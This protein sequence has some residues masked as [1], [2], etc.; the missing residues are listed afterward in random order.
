MREND[1][2][3]E[4]NNS[5]VVRDE[6]IFE[7]YLKTTQVLKSSKNPSFLKSISW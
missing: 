5:I 2:F 1:F 4:R 7:W 6:G 3:E